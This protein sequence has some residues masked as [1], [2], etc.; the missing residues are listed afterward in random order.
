MA[1][2]RSLY[3]LF[4][5][6]V[7]LLGSTRSLFAQEPEVGSTPQRV[8]GG[9]VERDSTKAVSA[10]PVL[11]AQSP[12]FKDSLPISRVAAI[13][14][15]A[16][17]FSQLYN[18]QYWKIPVL[19]GGVGAFSY[20]AI[21][22]NK[23][24]QRYKRQYD[25]LL[26]EYNSL[27][28]SGETI[29]DEKA[30]N[31][32]LKQ[33]KEFLSE[34]IDPV[35]TQMN[36]YNT[37]RTVYFAGAAFTYLYFLADGVMNYPNYTNNVKRATT[38]AMMFPGAGQMYNKSYWKVPIVVGAFTTMGYLIDWNQRNYNRMRDGY[39]TYDAGNEFSRQGIN[40]DL[41]KTR[42]DRFR[43]DRDLCI[44]LTGATYLLSVIEAHVDAHLKD[45]DISDDLTLWVEPTLID[46][47]NFHASQ[48]SG[49]PGVGLSMKIS[50]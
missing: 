5:I 36:K 48:N 35:R 19:Y 24:F 16:P 39:N 21:D 10:P 15:V 1:R 18:N 46:L 33:Q 31:E 30:R 2:R 25:L 28:I 3:I 8:S 32:F 29:S 40:K 47:N 37:Q 23:K 22:A 45:F 4:S 44:I 6:L 20:F 42:R 27:G 49:Y 17:G 11:R 38:L 41:L 26:S 14:L 50:F 13:S 12:I 7:L 34:R 9:V 43:R